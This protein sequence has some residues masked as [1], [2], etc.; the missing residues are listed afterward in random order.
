MS[1]FSPIPIIS[2]PSSEFF[3]TINTAHASPIFMPERFLLN[4]IDGLS[5]NTSRELKPYKGTFVKGSVQTIIT[6]SAILLFN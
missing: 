5:D 3:S 2:I 4:G 6:A 1:V